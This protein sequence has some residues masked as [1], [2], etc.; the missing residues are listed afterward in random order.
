VKACKELFPENLGKGW[1]S[2]G[3]M[4]T[5]CFTGGGA[6]QPLHFLWNPQK[7]AASH[8]GKNSSVN[9]VV[10]ERMQLHPPTHRTYR[11]VRSQLMHNKHVEMV[12][13]TIYWV[14]LKAMKAFSSLHRLSR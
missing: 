5:A 10:K 7:P 4:F 8:A 2:R 11:R 12:E 13:I 6:S 9:P 14:C 3:M 1:V